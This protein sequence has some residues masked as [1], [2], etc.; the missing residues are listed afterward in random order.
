MELLT[1]PFQCQPQA[2][3]VHLDL[4][5]RAVSVF[6]PLY[7]WQ[8]IYVLLSPG[9]R[10]QLVSYFHISHG[11][12]TLPC[13][14]WGHRCPAFSPVAC[15]FCLVSVWGGSGQCLRFFSSCIPLV[16]R[17][18]KLEVFL[19]FSQWQTSLHLCQ[20]R[21]RNWPAYSHVCLEH[22]IAS[23]GITAVPSAIDRPCTLEP[24]WR[25]FWGIFP[26]PFF[27]VSSRWR[28]MEKRWQVDENSPLPE[29]FDDE[30]IVSEGLQD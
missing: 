9:I 15:S 12:W 13:I 18:R 30:S 28:P 25:A 3:S 27:F 8:I 1:L 26:R 7:Q 16:P 29:F 20:W 4:I 2:S 23:P 22:G 14:V 17:T 19:T 11:N 21:I 6:L 5:D 24:M 10:V